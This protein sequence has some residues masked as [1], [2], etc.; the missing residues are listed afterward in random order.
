VELLGWLAFILLAHHI[1]TWAAGYRAQAYTLRPAPKAGQS[2]HALTARRASSS[3]DVA[4]MPPTAGDPAVTLARL[5]RSDMSGTAAVS[6]TTGSAD[7]EASLL[8]PC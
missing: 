6:V 3:D 5:P 2:P 4:A 1:T 7:P 8:P